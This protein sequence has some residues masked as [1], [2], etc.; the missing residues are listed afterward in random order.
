MTTK[1]N[2]TAV[3]IALMGLTITGCSTT[4]DTTA[5]NTSAPVTA[6]SVETSAR[7][8]ADKVSGFLSDSTD[9]GSS[10]AG[11][12][13]NR[14][15][16]GEPWADVNHNGCDTRN[17]ILARDLTNTVV[18]TDGCT[19]L[20]G[21]LNDSYTGD[22]IEFER[23][24][25]SSAVQIDHVIPLSYAWSHGADTW[26]DAQREAFA[27]DPENLIAV[28]GPA[29]MSK[30]DQ[31]PAEW[32]PENTSIHCQYVQDFA[33]VAGKYNLNISDADAQVANTVC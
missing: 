17:D 7:D 25:K 5:E 20:S 18:D 3:A 30:S 22:T 21:T 6:E 2:L 29:N 9:K 28:D 31:G 14:D 19:V 26:T 4:A 24:K 16:F 15:A 13:Y 27:N 11:T 1:K 33:Q 23:G 12:K 32:L 10:T 8:A